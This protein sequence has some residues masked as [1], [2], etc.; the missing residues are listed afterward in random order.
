ML[1]FFF[2][3]FLAGV[4]EAAALMVSGLVAVASVS[5]QGSGS[6]ITGGC[7]ADG[8]SAGTSSTKATGIFSIL[9]ISG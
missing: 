9:S 3:G 6:A 1:G 2:F 4:G 7:S 8:E 5:G